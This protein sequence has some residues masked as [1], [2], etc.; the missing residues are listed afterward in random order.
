MSSGMLKD[1]KFL[2]ALLIGLVLAGAGIIGYGVGILWLIEYGSSMESIAGT[3]FVGFGVILIPI[4]IAFGVVAITIIV[5]RVHIERR[6]R[7]GR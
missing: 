1:A 5:D 2:F 4:G 7:I 6:A 3:F